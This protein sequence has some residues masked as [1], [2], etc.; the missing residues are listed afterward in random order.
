MTSMLSDIIFH[1]SISDTTR[2]QWTVGDPFMAV[3]MLRQEYNGKLGRIIGDMNP[4]TFRFPVKFEGAS[5]GVQLQPH[6]MVPF[7][8]LCTVE[9]DGRPDPLLVRNTGSDPS[10]GR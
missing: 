1:G 9:G 2:W 4:A 5:T 8:P 6:N 7:A 3:G 10:F